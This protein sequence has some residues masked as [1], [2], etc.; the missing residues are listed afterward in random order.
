MHKAIQERNSR[1][2]VAVSSSR[3]SRLVTDQQQILQTLDDL[4]EESCKPFSPALSSLENG[5]SKNTDTHSVPK[6][7]H[8]QSLDLLESQEIKSLGLE[9][10]DQAK[11]VTFSG[12]SVHKEIE[13]PIVTTDQQA[14]IHQEQQHI[15]PYKSHEITNSD[16]KKEDLNKW[17]NFNIDIHVDCCTSEETIMSKKV[18]Y[19][20]SCKNHYNYK[21]NITNREVMDFEQSLP[22]KDHFSQENKLKAGGLSILPQQEAVNFSNS[23]NTAVSEPHVANYEQYIYGTSFGHSQGSP[24]HTSLACTRT[25][26]TH[27]VSQLTNH[28][29][30]FQRPQ[31]CSSPSIPTSLMNQTNTHIVEKVNKKEGTKR[32]YTDKGQ[33][34]NFSNGPLSTV[35]H[36]QVIETTE[37]EKRRQDL[38]ESE[39]IH[40]ID[41]HSIDNMNKE[42]TNISQASQRE[43]KEISHKPGISSVDRFVHISYRFTYFIEISN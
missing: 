24:E 43:E 32:N 14:Q 36:S 2:T 12:L 17:E 37:V 25:I 4:P 8:T 11:A 39:I 34:P 33:K 29:E 22:S 19:S 18:I 23:D 31:N 5:L 26:S 28:V 15:S 1:K 27:E 38:A 35:V 6:E 41:F 7:T 13:L 42:L 16:E 40:N 10:S 21:E 30:Q 20:T 9:S 3:R